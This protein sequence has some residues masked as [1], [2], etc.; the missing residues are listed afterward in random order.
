[1][2]RGVYFDGWYRHN[3]C[4][5][6]TLP[7][8][9]LQ[10]VDDLQIFKATLLV[11]SALGGGSISLPFLEHEAFGEVDP[12][13]R[14]YGFMNDSEFIEE[15]QNRGIKV[16]GIVFEAQGWEL[17]AVLEKD[18]KAFKDLNV[19]RT[20]EHHDWYG[21]REFGRDIHRGVF[22]TS[23]QHYF[24]DGLLD[25]DGRPI[26]D[27][28]ED[29]ATRRLDGKPCHTEWVEMP[30]HAHRC[31]LMCR[32]NPAW[33]QY[34][35]KILEIQIDA[36]VAGIQLDEPETPLASVQYGGCFCRSCM[37][38]FR[39]YL[40]TLATRGERVGSMSPADLDGFHYGEYLKS[41]GVAYPGNPK[42]V[43]LFKQY[44]DFQL[45]SFKRFF[46]ELVAHAK[47]YAG[48]KG[49]EILVS[50]NF[51]NLLPPCFPNEPAVDLVITEMKQTLFKQPYWYRYA[52]G[53]A[54]K[55]PLVVVENPYGGI[56]P[57]LVD[58][59]NRGRGFDLYRLLLLEAAVYGCNM[60]VPYGAWMGN[61]VKDCF[62]PPRHVTEEV[63]GFL[64]EKAGLYSKSSGSRVLV[65]Y[66]FPSYY[67]REVTEAYSQENLAWENEEDLLSYKVAD[68]VDPRG[69][70]L[71]FWEIVRQ[72]SSEQVIYDVKFLADGALRED[73]FGGPDL[74]G[75][76]LIVLPDCVVLT[77][78]QARVLEEYAEEGRRILIFGRAAENLPGWLEG[79]RQRPEVFLCADDMDKPTAL[80]RF[81]AVFRPLFEPLWRVRLDDA[82]FGI[83]TH[84]LDRGAAI[85]LLN[86][87]Y[88]ADG[89]RVESS[90]RL[91]LR[92]RNMLF[93]GI[94][95]IHC[96][97]GQSLR[98]EREAAGD[99]ILLKLYDVPL[100]TIL[101]LL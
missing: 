11:W 27:L 76:N 93:G 62:D 12:R 84:K 30:G 59:L 71:P 96:L 60:A 82:S 91:T 34:L 46:H 33:R 4:Y 57:A 23:F 17:P 55:K 95:R 90:D 7:F 41:M 63:Q 28:W 50:A 13:L 6:P 64:A 9:S 92:I 54:G 73:E 97:Q 47:S 86:Y 75:Y 15:C 74:K 3:H 83:H 49:R 78:N 21:L 16:F 99:T 5:H 26:S 51:F 44:W 39:E 79:V 98:H 42:E 68:M 19:V 70:R 40:K 22:G 24:P 35:K 8:R 58:R 18:G 101:E 32:N 36:G 69:P 85:H 53:F 1:M 43:P 25:I 89:D 94:V 80:E 14:F 77:E 100:Y 61:R 48:S 20:G 72:L 52:S 65:L 56:V 81:S 45:S 37:K 29:C 87:K 66:S 88:V 38:Q 31:H 67:W 2:E 10:M